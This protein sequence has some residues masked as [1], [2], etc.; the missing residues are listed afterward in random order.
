MAIRRSP[1]SGGDRSVV[2]HIL[3]IVTDAN[4]EKIRANHCVP[5]YVLMHLPSKGEKID[6]F[7]LDGW[8]FTPKCSTTRLGFLFLCSPNPFYP[9]PSYHWLN[10]A[11]TLRGMMIALAT[12][13]SKHDEGK[14]MTRGLL[15]VLLILKTIARFS[16]F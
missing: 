11:L 9:S 7:F 14:K 2:A 6:S 5:D 3:S 1:S 15:N 12:I 4:L 13:W 8:D 16:G 10:L